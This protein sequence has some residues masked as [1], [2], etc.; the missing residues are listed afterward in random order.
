MEAAELASG[1]GHRDENF[2]VASLI[3]RPEYRAPVMAYYRFA[4]AA[5]DIADNPDAPQEDKLARWRTCARVCRVGSPEAMALRDVMAERGIDPVHAHDLLDAFVR[6]V[7]VDRYADWDDLIGYCRLSAMPVGRYVL[8]VHGES[9]ATWAAND[10]LC[11]ALQII[12]HLQDCAKDY[13]TIGRVYIP[14]DT[15]L[16][17]TDLGADHASPSLRAIIAGLAHRTNGLLRQ[18]AGFAAQIRDRRLA[19][20]VAAIQ[21]LAES[22]CDRLERRDPLCENVHHSKIEAL[23]LGASA[24]IPTLLRRR[25]PWP[26]RS[27]PAAAAAAVSMPGC[28]SCPRP[29][30]KRC[31]PS[32]ASAA[33]S[34]TSPTISRAIA[35]R[36]WPNSMPG[37]TISI[38][39]MRAVRP[40]GRRWSPMRCAGSV[41]NAPI[42]RR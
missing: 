20:E 27:M 30:A 31:T 29:S 41:S 26:R 4:R 28:A 1:K 9:R 17:V 19:A 3:I 34:M 33:S 11:A 23:V 13:A 24:A 6:D 36:A 15:G 10:A 38:R 32:T 8:D 16:H 7:T 21:R 22:L 42:S 18:S 2:P 14:L 39:S 25:N 37:G 12:N 40:A 5:D 35:T